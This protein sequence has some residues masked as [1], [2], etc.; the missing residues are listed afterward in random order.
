[1]YRYEIPSLWNEL[2][3]RDVSHRFLHSTS[4]S[5]PLT[6]IVHETV[7]AVDLAQV[8][9]KSV[10]LSTHQQLTAALALIA[11]DGVARR[12]IVCPPDFPDTQVLSVCEK[13]EVDVILSDRDASCF[14]TVNAIPI[15]FFGSGPRSAVGPRG[16][17]CATEW[18]LFTSGT[19]GTPKLVAHDLL[20]LT[21]AIKRT[22]EL[23]EPHVWG[24]F[25][26]IRRYG[27]LQILPAG[28]AGK[29]IL[30][31]VSHRRACLRSPIP[32]D[33]PAKP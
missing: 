28:D 17:I 29:C 24:T 5:V 20:G 18:V 21:H 1:M 19:T 13:A 27:G 30:G 3:S 25:Y 26:D 23:Q 6:D 31:T 14:Q 9:H 4:A 2:A 11:L 8:A 16:A 22:P 15:V 33:H 12:I 10:L 32:S 7:A